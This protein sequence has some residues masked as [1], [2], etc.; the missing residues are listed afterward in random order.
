MISTEK[1]QIC[2]QCQMD[3]FCAR[4][5]TALAIIQS[6]VGSTT[7]DDI[8]KRL[9]SIR[10]ELDLAGF[11]YPQGE[12]HCSYATDPGKIQEITNELIRLT[13]RIQRDSADAKAPHRRFYNEEVH[14]E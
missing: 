4:L 1:K 5:K 7:E 11:R 6:S 13:A 14:S 2:D 9:E 10:Q 3:Y 8:V 12:T